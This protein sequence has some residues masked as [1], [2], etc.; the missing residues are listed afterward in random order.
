MLFRIKDER[1]SWQKTTRRANARLLAVNDL[2]CLCDALRLCAFAR[3]AR[4]ATSNSAK[5]QSPPR[6]N[7]K[8]R[9]ILV[10]SLA[11][12]DAHAGA[13]VFV[14]IETIDLNVRRNYF[15]HRAK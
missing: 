4:F 13:P 8:A 10:H 6:K 1:A 9:K 3:N 15:C 14:D 12:H 2:F 11:S 5:S 7:R